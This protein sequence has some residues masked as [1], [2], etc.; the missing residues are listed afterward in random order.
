[1]RLPS[2]TRSAVSGMLERFT[3]RNGQAA[4]LIRPA[5]YNSSGT[6]VEEVQVSTTVLIGYE[7]PKEPHRWDNWG[8]KNIANPNPQWAILK[9]ELMPQENDVLSL[10]SEKYRLANINPADVIFSAVQGWFCHLVREEG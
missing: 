7:E 3:E 8:R 1:M 2:R 5:R 4:T 6:Y 10:W 9:M